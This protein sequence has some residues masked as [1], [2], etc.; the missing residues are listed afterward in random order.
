MVDKEVWILGSSDLTGHKPEAVLLDDGYKLQ[1]L[2]PGSIQAV[3]RE[4]A[5]AGGEL[6]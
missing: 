1:Y 5:G 2:P 3:G 4:A 6:H